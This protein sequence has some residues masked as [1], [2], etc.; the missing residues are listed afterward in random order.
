MEDTARAGSLLQDF[1]YSIECLIKLLSTPSFPPVCLA[2]TQI[3]NLR[4]VSPSFPAHIWVVSASATTWLILGDGNHHKKNTFRTVHIAEGTLTGPCT[5]PSCFIFRLPTLS[6]C[7]SVPE[8]ISVSPGMLFYLC[9]KQA[10]SSGE[11]TAQDRPLPMTN[12]H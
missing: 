11:P 4:M 12:K 5:G 10:W 3:F 9:T 7:F 8:A 6:I 2:H 1:S